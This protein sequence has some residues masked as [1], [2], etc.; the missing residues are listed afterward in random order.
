MR[1]LVT[2]VLVLLCSTPVLAQ[3][4]VR[5]NDFI[6]R[7]FV[8]VVANATWNGFQEGCRDGYGAD[9]DRDQDRGTASK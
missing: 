9:G 7:V 8:D 1:R 3:Q 5:E 6:G 2:F 4:S